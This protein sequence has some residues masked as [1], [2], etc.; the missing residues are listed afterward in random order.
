MKKVAKK[1]V[2]KINS[3]LSINKRKTSKRKKPGDAPGTLIHTGE[4]VLDDIL[5]TVHDF[6]EEHFT[7]LPVKEVEKLSPFLKSKSKTWLQVRGLHDID[8]LKSIWN[9]FNLHP[10]VQED[11]VSTNQRPKIELY[12]DFIFIVLRSLTP[13]S[14]NGDNININNEQISIV[15]VK[16]LCFRFR[17]AT[18]PY[19]NP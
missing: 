13:G 4:R 12:N 8:K 10:L 9:Y 16:T 14:V 17:K 6:D 18:N 15:L 19:L 2:K 7:S 3:L 5:I 11:I 1:S